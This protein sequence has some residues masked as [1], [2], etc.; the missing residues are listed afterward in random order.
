MKSSPKDQKAIGPTFPQELAAA[1]L[2]GEH[3]SWRPTGEIEFFEDTP[4]QVKGSVLEVYA[5][6]DPSTG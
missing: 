2:L 6:H 4:D 1:G 3:F 5:A